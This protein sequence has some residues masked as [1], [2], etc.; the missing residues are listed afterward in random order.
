MYHL[1]IDV[2]KSI[3]LENGFIAQNIFKKH[4]MHSASVIG[5]GGETERNEKVSLNLE[6]S[7]NSCDSLFQD[8]SQSQVS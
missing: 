7:N 3:K 1:I 6:R 4:L 8:Q 5:L 2:N